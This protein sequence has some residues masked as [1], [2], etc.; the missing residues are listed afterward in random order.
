MAEG[1]EKP[2][3]RATTDEWERQELVAGY[4]AMADLN[5]DMA[6]ADIAAVNEVWALY[7]E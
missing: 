2:N 4:Q 5:R 3:L 1:T 6:E 7:D